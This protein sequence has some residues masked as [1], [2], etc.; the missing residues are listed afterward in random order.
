M[1]QC[2]FEGM[3]DFIRHT[4]NKISDLQIS[5]NQKEQEIGFLRS[6]LSKLSERVEELEKAADIKFGKCQNADGSW[7]CWSYMVMI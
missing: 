4:E 1:D 3:K 6:M 7:F 5:N 2:Q